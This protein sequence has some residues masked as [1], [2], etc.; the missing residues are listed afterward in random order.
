MCKINEVVHYL[1]GS[2]AYAI[3]CGSWFVC[4]GICITSKNSDLD[5]TV[6]VSEAEFYIKV[7]CVAQ[8]KRI[9]NMMRRKQLCQKA[10]LITGKTPLIT[11]TISD[12]ETDITFQ[13]IH[14]LKLLVSC[15]KFDEMIFLLTTAIFIC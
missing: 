14:S 1:Y 5:V 11:C 13:N 15:R 8:L 9:I 12:I 6:I 2:K 7:G 4:N 10:I 3:A